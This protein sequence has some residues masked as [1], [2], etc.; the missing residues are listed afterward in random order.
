MEFIGG[1]LYDGYPWFEVY[2]NGS[3]IF[4]HDPCV[5]GE[6]P[7]S[8]FPPMEH[9]FEADDPQHPPPTG[10]PIWGWQ[11]VPGQ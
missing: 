5:T 1:G 8:M 2:L 9:S 11:V 10:I 7:F 4:F 3:P 6:G